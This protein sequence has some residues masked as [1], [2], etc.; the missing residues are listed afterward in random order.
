[1]SILAFQSRRRFQVLFQPQRKEL[2]S[3]PRLCN[4]WKR[5][6]QGWCYLWTMH[7]YELDKVQGGKK[8]KLA[9]KN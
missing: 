5:Q 4:G 8:A 7:D 2:F 9:A 3:P 1:M 6:P